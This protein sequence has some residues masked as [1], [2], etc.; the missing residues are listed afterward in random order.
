MVVAVRGVHSLFTLFFLSCLAYVYY[1]ALARK[2]NRLL[3]AATGALLIEGAVVR[4]NGGDCP[5]G[6]I[7]HRYGDEKTFFEL[8]VP[9]RLAKR[10]VPFF[11]VVTAVG[12]ALA[13][14]RPPKG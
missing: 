12:L 2:R 3:A 8:F 11:T 4:A 9:P 5:L 10:A 7:H 6:A 13:I 14:A 1:A